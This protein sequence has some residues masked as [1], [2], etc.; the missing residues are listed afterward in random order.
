MQRDMIRD[1]GRTMPIVA[2]EAR[3]WKKS[4]FMQMQSSLKVTVTNA[5]ATTREDG[6]AIHVTRP[7]MYV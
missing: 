7:C 3:Y 2:F 5:L 6:K 1:K 4:P